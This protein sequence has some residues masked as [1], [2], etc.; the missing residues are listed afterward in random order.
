MEGTDYGQ[1]LLS[2][3]VV[4]D[5]VADPPFFTGGQCPATR[6]CRWSDAARAQYRGGFSGQRGVISRT[7]EPNRKRNNL[8]ITRTFTINGEL[9]S[10]GVVGAT[11]NKIGRTTGWTQG[12][13]TQTNVT[14]SVSGS[15]ITMLGQ[16][17]VSA[18]VGGGDSG[19]PVFVLGSGSNVTLLG[20]L[21]GGSSNGRSFVYSPISTVEGELGPLAST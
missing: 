10:G 5:E 15:N 18:G 7:S 2:Q 12:Q 1:P 19:S 17:L 8:E 16:T 14:T 3:G 20:I 13:I 4:A 6:R 21:W 9:A 11:A